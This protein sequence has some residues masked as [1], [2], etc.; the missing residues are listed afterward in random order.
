[1]A[2]LTGWRIPPG[3]RPG[4][5][6]WPWACWWG[7]YWPSAMF[8]EFAAVFLSYKVVNFGICALIVALPLGL[9]VVTR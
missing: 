3:Q 5:C 2:R 9:Y 6:R 7:Y 4:L 1:L 8:R